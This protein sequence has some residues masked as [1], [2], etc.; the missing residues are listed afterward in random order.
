MKK[1]NRILSLLLC[2][3]LVFACLCGS[4]VTQ[5]AEKEYVTLGIDNTAGDSNPFYRLV[6]HKQL[7]GSGGPFTVSMEI[8]LEN[9]RRISGSQYDPDAFVNAMIGIQGEE[10]SVHGAIWHGSGNSDWQPVS[11]TFGNIQATMI[12]GAIQEY[13][14]MD[15]GLF[16]VRAK[17]T[18]RNFKITN[19]AGDVVW[20]F[21]TNEDFRKIT[22]IRNVQEVNFESYIYQCCFG[23]NIGGASYP[24]KV[25]T[26]GS[27]ENSVEV[28]SGPVFETPSTPGTDTSKPTE[29]EKPSAPITSKPAEDEKSSTADTSVPEDSSKEDEVTSGEDAST[30]ADDTSVPSVDTSTPVDDPSKPTGNEEQSPGQTVI[31]KSLAPWVIPTLIAVGVVL[32]AGIGVVIFLLLKKKT[33]ENGE[34]EPETDSSDAE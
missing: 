26:E 33:S 18:V 8:K 14:L 16:Y 10:G 15:F 19:A 22:D 13:G 9:W 2:L 29:S 3:T 32:I 24:V 30:P 17:M 31:V 23:E 4:F 20:S 1:A 25:V 5:A 11:F 7:F 28:S 34:E 12:D 27:E 21:D 6:L